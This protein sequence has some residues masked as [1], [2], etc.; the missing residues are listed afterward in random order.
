MTDMA[1]EAR[2]SRNAW[3]AEVR[4]TFGLAWPLVLTNLAQTGMT[5]T[6][7]A[8]I[9]RL[10]PDALAAA[11]LAT[12]V[13]FAALICAIGLVSA[14][15]PMIARERGGKPHS[16][17]DVRRTFRQGMW[18]AVAISIPIWIVLWFTGPLRVLLGQEPRLAEAAARYMPA[19]QWSVLPFLFYIV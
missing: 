6:D 16:V 19:L 13:Y 2:R 11:A 4:A 18:S 15:A 3:S 5:T 17:R 14:T 7:V 8:L 1:A 12:N 10:G 9:G